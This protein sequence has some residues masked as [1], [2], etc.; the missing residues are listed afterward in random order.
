VN[1]NLIIDLAKLEYPELIA[2]YFVLINIKKI[3]VDTYDRA[4]KRMQKTKML[5]R[6]LTTEVGN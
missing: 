2:S 4:E 5:L 1:G 3:V 6:Q